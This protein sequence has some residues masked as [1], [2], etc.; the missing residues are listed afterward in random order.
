MR[1][2]THGI[3]RHRLPHRI[4]L[5]THSIAWLRRGA[6]RTHGQRAKS[7]KCSRALQESSAFKKVVGQLIFLHTTPMD[8]TDASL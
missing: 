3:F 7:E 1:F 2:I 5:Q 8:F 4:E 6:R